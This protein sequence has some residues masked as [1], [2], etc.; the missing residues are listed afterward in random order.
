MKKGK[1]ERFKKL[2]EKHMNKHEKFEK[3][4]SETFWYALPKSEDGFAY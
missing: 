3:N 1:I 4:E 2:R